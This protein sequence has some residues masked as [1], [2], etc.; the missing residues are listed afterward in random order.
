MNG[1]DGR[2]GPRRRTNSASRDCRREPLGRLSVSRLLLTCGLLALAALMTQRMLSPL[3][4]GWHRAEELLAGEDR[5]VAL[6]DEA[7]RLSEEIAYKKT[8]GGQALE[9]FE[10]KGVVR[11]GGRVAKPVPKSPPKAS[12]QPRTLAGRAKAWRKT[13][14]LCLYSKW[15]VLALC[16]FDKRLPP[17]ERA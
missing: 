14:W 10:Q 4:L 3:A 9:A 7:R 6:D 5:L 17:P 16:L 1:Q 15:R 13:G 11:R 8:G 12:A 2:S